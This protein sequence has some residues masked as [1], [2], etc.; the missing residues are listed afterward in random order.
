VTTPFAIPLTDVHVTEP[1]V[2]AVLAALERGWQIDGPVTGRFEDDFAAWH[3]VPDAVA[4]ANGT[5]A[6][7]L[8]LAGLG[9]GPGDEVLVPGLTFV[10]SAAAVRQVGATPVLCD[11]V[12]A[13]RPLLDPADAARRVTPRTRAIVAVHFLGYPADMAALRALADE[14]GLLVVEDC[15]QGIGARMPGGALAGTVGDAGCFSLFS[16]KQL[17]AGEGGVVVTR[18]EATLQRVRGLR[19]A[20]RALSDAHAA[21]AASRLVRLDAGLAARRA[22]VRA[23]RERL[24]GIDGLEVPFSDDDVELATHFAF[25]VLVGDRDRR[26]AVRAALAA[27]GIQTTWYPALTRL[28]AYADAPSLPRAEE[29]ADRHLALPLS[30]DTTPEQI[31][32][33]VEALRAALR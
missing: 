10:A 8:A 27:S 23:Y 16:K 5:T 7:E 28:T 15:A 24:A 18:E 30:A 1:D 25:T 13:G 22:N 6:L 19:D 32:A 4:V 11:V 26:D 21:L 17:C 12:A 31:G 2:A 33:V 29:A 9:V 20:E 14:H 3:G